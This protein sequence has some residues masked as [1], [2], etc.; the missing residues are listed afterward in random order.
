MVVHGRLTQANRATVR[1]GMAVPAPD[2]AG[3]SDWDNTL[4]LTLTGEVVGWHLEPAY[5]QRAGKSSVIDI[6]PH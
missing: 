1:V 4:G 5:A 2:Y 6:L 3:F